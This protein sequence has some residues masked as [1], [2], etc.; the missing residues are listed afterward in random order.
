MTYA[1]GD[2]SLRYYANGK[3]RATIITTALGSNP[4]PDPLAAL[5][6]LAPN[7][8]TIGAAGGTE[9]VPGAGDPVPGFMNKGITGKID[10]VRFFKR[11]LTDIQVESLFILGGQGR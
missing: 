6:L 5:L 3:L 1:P 7:T 2:H 4:F 8:T 10:D 9:T 11:Q